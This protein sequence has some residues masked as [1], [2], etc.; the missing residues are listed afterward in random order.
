MVTE[1]YQEIN[2]AYGLIAR[3]AR[4]NGIIVPSPFWIQPGFITRTA[5]DRT[6][7]ISCSRSS[8]CLPASATECRATSE[9]LVTSDESL[10]FPEKVA[11][12]V[13]ERALLSLDQCLGLQHHQI[14][15]Y[16]PSTLYLRRRELI[17]CCVDAALKAS[18]QILMRATLKFELPESIKAIFH[19]SNI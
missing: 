9:H 4:S 1:R 2:F 7:L 3:A 13:S 19:I 5:L 8:R 11:C 16:G 17:A 6:C 15:R 18:D 14:S 12:C 10:E